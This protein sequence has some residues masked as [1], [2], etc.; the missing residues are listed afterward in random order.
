MYSSV[1]AASATPPCFTSFRTPTIVNHGMLSPNP[2]FTLAP[3]GLRSEKNFRT[4]ASFTS[5]AGAPPMS[6]GSNVRPWTTGIPIVS[7]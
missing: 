4:S 6:A 2:G 7:V 3:M 5:T 1:P